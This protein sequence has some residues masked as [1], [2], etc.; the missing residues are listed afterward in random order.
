MGPKSIANV[1][2]QIERSKARGLAR[3][4][5]GLSIR[6]VGSQNAIVLADEFGS[7]D[8]I[9]RASVEQLQAA[10]GIGERIAE[11]VRFFFSQETNRAIVDRLR[12]AGV[13][14]T[15][16]KATKG[17]GGK[18]AGKTFVLTGTLPTMTR[19][20]ASELI[21]AAGGKVS[22]S[23]SKKTD[24]VVAGSE[25]GGK[26]TRAQELGTPILD[27]AGLRKLLSA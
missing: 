17:A 3:V 6:Y 12:R 18:L 24:Y 16:P 19:E 26:L 8:E 11:S 13:V 10:E 7:I 22:G 21:V 9:A 23:V 27:E 4:L 15:A 2:E 1:L 5:V 14:L 25:A 20:Q